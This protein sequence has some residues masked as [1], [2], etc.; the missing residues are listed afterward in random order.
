[1][2]EEIKAIDVMNYV[3]TP[4]VMKPFL[5]S[6]EMKM[7]GISMFGGK[8]PGIWTAGLEPEEFITQMDEANVEKTLICAFK[9]WSYRDRKFIYDTTIDRAQEI[10][11][12]YPDRLVGLATYNPFRIK[13]SLEDME[14]AVKEYGFKGVYVH[15]LCY[16]L[17]PNDRVMYPCYAKCVE[18]GIPFAYQAGH[19]LEHLPSEPGRPMYLDDVM[20]DFPDLTIIG[21]HTGWPWCE[22][23][24]AMAWKWPTVYIDIAAHMPRYLDKSLVQFMNT[25]GRGKVLWGSNGLNPEVLIDELMK[26][27]L[28]EETYKK[29]LRENAIKVYKL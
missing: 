5:E 11:S 6:R 15:T 27:E 18:L 21:S 2:A 9:M 29:V 20:L 1:M 26:L 19:S 13:E 24:I 14:R 8:V 10:I 25:R 4:D 16:G 7:M 22:E 23:M 12:K 17:R 3:F 28:R